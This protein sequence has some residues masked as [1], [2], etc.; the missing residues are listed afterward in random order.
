MKK[1]HKKH[2]NKAGNEQLTSH[3]FLDTD[4]HTDIKVEGIYDLRK[5]WETLTALNSI[6]KIREVKKDKP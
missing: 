5:I 4:K 1:G 3:V 6:I 2:Q